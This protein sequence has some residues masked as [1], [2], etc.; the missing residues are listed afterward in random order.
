MSIENAQKEIKLM[1][2]YE[3]YITVLKERIASKDEE[4]KFLKEQVK[5]KREE[6]QTLLD[7]MATWDESVESWVM[8]KD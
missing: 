1:E 3:A 6:T 4:I 5:E 8:K 7:A 2:K